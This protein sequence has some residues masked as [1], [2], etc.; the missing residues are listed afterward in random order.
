MDR[1]VR[2]IASAQNLAVVIAPTVFEYEANAKLIDGLLRLADGRNATIMPLYHGANSRGSLELGAMGEVLPGVAPASG[3]GL[4]LADVVEG[5]AEPKVIYLVGEV[6]FLQRPDCDYV[7]AQCIYPP[8]FEV[9]AFLPAASFAESDGT[10]IN[11][12]GRVQQ[13]MAIED[14]PDGA[15]TGSVRPDWFIFSQLAKKLK[16]PGFN[17]KE[18]EDV[19]REIA[20]NVPGI[21]PTPDRR[22]RR[23]K[24]KVDLP[25]TRRRSAGKGAGSYL[26]VAQP[27]GFAHR[28]VDLS[29]KVEGLKELALEEGFR[30][31]PADLKRLRVKPGQNITIRMGK[32]EVTAS[33]KADE[34]CLEGTV[35]FFRPSSYGGL[36][37]RADL[38][39]LYRMRRSP[40][41]VSVR[42]A[43]SPATRRGTKAPVR[44]A[45]IAR[46]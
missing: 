24:P 6:P 14:H 4:S 12:E 46:G 15:V 41:R 31:N 42:R 36:G 37:H 43:G 10:L 29:S 21:P 16:S 9:D 38:E 45:G 13:L 28:G 39:P 18:S 33:A 1:A 7:I 30:L 23:L 44:K 20:R 40:V 3:K 27:A 8:P 22:P 35:Y 32:L 19:L 5:R 26:L 11:I 34:E 25:V 2:A 17:Y